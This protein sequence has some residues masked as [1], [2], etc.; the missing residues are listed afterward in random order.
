MF[1]SLLN[2][3]AVRIFL[4]KIWVPNFVFNWANNRTM[5]MFFEMC[6]NEE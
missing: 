5:D 6:E 1:N 3:I 4:S 2:Q